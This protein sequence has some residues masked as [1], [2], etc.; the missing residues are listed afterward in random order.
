[1]IQS[2]AAEAPALVFPFEIHL[3]RPPFSMNPQ[4]YYQEPTGTIYWNAQIVAGYVFSLGKDWGLDTGIEYDYF[5][6]PAS[7]PLQTLGLRTGLVFS[8]SLDGPKKAP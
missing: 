7:T 6:P 4:Q 5:W 2:R 1:M 8:F 3:P